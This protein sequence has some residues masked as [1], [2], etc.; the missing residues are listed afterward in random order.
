M[1]YLKISMLWMFCGW[2]FAAINIEITP[3]QP[4]IN[5]EI[6]LVLK[7]TDSH[8]KSP[9]DL[10]V[11]ANDF[12]IIGTQQS[13]AYQ[14]INGHASQENMW[15]IVMHAR[16]AGKI[17]IPGIQWGNEKTKPV[18]IDVKNSI[19]TLDHETPAVAQ[20]S[21]FMKWHIEPEH[22]VLH[23]QMKVHLEIYHHLPLLDAKL[24]P[25]TVENGLL[26]SLE[27]HRHRIEMIQGKRYEVEKYE[28]MIYPQKIG[29]M[30][31][32][33]PVLNAMEYDMIPTPIHETIKAETFK[34]TA[35]EGHESLND[36]LPAKDLRFEELKPLKT[37]M[38]LKAGDTLSRKIR[39]EAVGVPGNLLPDIQPRC[40]ENCKVYINPAKITNKVLQGELHGTKTFEMT[41]LPTREGDFELQAIEIPWFNTQTRK[42][43]VLKIPAFELKVFKDGLVNEESHSLMLS[44]K[45]HEQHWPLWINLLIATI[46]GMGLMKG[47]SYI[48]W[49]NWW[50]SLKKQDWLHGQLKRACMNN[51]AYKV[52]EWILQWANHQAFHKPIRDLHDIAIQV[53]DE[54]FKRQLSDLNKCLYAGKSVQPWNGEAFWHAFVVFRKKISN[55]R[56]KSKNSSILDSLN[57]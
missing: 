29:N 28:Y 22:P 23:E 32:H 36:W 27:Q 7:Q 20:R 11:L 52:R 49:K 13:M 40:G 55:K 44:P 2:A 39:I 47:W 26:F 16:H 51:D 41:Y 15:T 19:N 1:K 14:F 30:V 31:V 56:I 45:A 50:C 37:D 12:Q 48:P 42:M 38:G 53:E 35:P 54:R 6:Q 4:V 43:Q 8:D 3:Q 57:P 17:T 18:I 5:D 21:V 34:I 10:S 24:S 25:P 33:G 46:T 9:P